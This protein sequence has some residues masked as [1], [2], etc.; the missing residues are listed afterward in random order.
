MT[1]NF[2]H[3]GKEYKVLLL[4]TSEPMT[5]KGATANPT[6]SLCNPYVFNTAI[7]RAQSLVVSVGNP[8]LLL[9]M[10]ENMTK[11]PEYKEIGKC[12]SN[13]FK[14]C[15]ENGS[16]EI[17]SSLDI[18]EEMKEEIFMKIKDLAEKSLN[19]KIQYPVRN[20]NQI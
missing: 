9:K 8:F 17:A 15:L 4:S 13:Y 10:E 19:E 16:M 14:C 7:T 2:I 6:K 18:C 11:H 1:F 12:W 20:K 3:A 5:E